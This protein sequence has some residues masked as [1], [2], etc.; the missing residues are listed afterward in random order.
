MQRQ[1]EKTPKAS[2]KRVQLKLV[3][4]VLYRRELS[5]VNNSR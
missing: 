1:I 5:A 2:V 4:P 3:E